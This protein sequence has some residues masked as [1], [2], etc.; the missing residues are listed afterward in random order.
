MRHLAARPASRTPPRSRRGA[1]RNAPRLRLREVPDGT[2][3]RLPRDG[4]P[5]RARLPEGSSRRSAATPSTRRSARDADGTGDP[6]GRRAD[7]FVGACALIRPRRRSPTSPSSRPEAAEGEVLR[8]DRRPQLRHERVEEWGIPSRPRRPDPRVAGP[9]ADRLGLGAR[10]PPTSRRA[11]SAEP[12]TLRLVGE[13]N[14]LRSRPHNRDRNRRRRDRG[15][16]KRRPN[17]RAR[18]RRPLD[19]APEGGGEEV[20]AGRLAARRGRGAP[21]SAFGTISTEN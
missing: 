7:R 20:R 12:R 14:E 13:P 1:R 19:R 17:L 9:I 4:D 18:L 21:G 3:P 16:A 11:R 15:R 6:R 2:G 5:E 10:P 8:A